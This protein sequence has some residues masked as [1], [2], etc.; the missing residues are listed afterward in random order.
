MKN[1][2]LLGDSIRIHYKDRVAELLGPDVTVWT[3]QENCRFSQYLLWGIRDWWFHWGEPKLDAAHFNAG[4]WDCHRATPDG[5]LFTP[6]DEYVD[7]MKRIAKTL[8]YFTPNV[9]FATT[10]PGWINPGNP[11]LNEF[12]ELCPPVAVWNEDIRR[13]NEAATKSMLEMGVEI[14]DLHALVS[15]DPARFVSSDGVHMSPEGNEA[16]AQQVAGK[17]RSMLGI[18]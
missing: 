12:D 6:I 2:L 13:Y 11:D 7:H 1:V 4:I 16:L 5:E 3:P 10:T 14:N 17:I 15:T 8:Q 9:C 18:T